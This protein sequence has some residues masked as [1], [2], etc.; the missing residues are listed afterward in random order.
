MIG[1][2][3]IPSDYMVAVWA[4]RAGMK[5]RFVRRAVKRNQQ[6][7]RKWHRRW[8][9]AGYEFGWRTDRPV[10]HF[11]SREFMERFPGA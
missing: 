1:P 9:A 3:F 11:V 7:R 4:R 10:I 8:R 6:I 2:T 5:A